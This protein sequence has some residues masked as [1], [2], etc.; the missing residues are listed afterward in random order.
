MGAGFGVDLLDGDN[1]WPAIM[2]ALDTVGYNTWACAE[3][4]GGGVDRMKVVAEKMDR[5]LAM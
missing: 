4:G 5:I 2:K 1:D 3:V